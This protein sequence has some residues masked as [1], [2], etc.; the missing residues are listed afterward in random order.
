MKDK[1]LEGRTLEDTGYNYEHLL[2]S[3]KPLFP[4]KAIILAITIIVIAVLAY[5]AYLYFMPTDMVR[6]N[7]VEQVGYDIPNI[8]LRPIALKGTIINNYGEEIEVSEVSFAIGGS[9][10]VNQELFTLEDVL[11]NYTSDS[12]SLNGTVDFLIKLPEFKDQ[13]YHAGDED[14]EYWIKVLY[15]GYKNDMETFDVSYLYI[16]SGPFPLP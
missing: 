2:V 11:V 13:Y 14:P 3:Q 5:V 1:A 8:G 12:I 9:V 7:N 10:I 4:W 16:S 15:N 6:F